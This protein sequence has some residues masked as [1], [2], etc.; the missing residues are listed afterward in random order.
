MAGSK[1]SLL[2]G[3]DSGARN[4]DYP[5]NGTRLTAIQILNVDPR[6]MISFVT[7]KQ[8]P[9][10]VGRELASK[11]NYAARWNGPLLSH[12]CGKKNAPEVEGPN[13]HARTCLRQPTRSYG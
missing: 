2:V 9:F 10:G 3:G 7:V 13:T 11:R 8:Q 4:A 5:G 6:G 1:G 12:T